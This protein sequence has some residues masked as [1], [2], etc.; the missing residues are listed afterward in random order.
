MDRTQRPTL[1]LAHY[2]TRNSYGPPNE[3][4]TP[5][6]LRNHRDD[7]GPHNQRWLATIG[8]RD[9]EIVKLKFEIKRLKRKAEAGKPPKPTA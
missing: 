3:P 7:P 5:E 1:C 8:E 4:F 9:H 2:M 6:E